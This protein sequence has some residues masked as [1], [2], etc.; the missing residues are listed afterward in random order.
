[1]AKQPR[2]VEPDYLPWS[3]YKDRAWHL[4]VGDSKNIPQAPSIDDF[5]ELISYFAPLLEILIFGMQK[6]P[7]EAIEELIIEYKSGTINNWQVKWWG[8]A[9]V[10][11]HAW[12]VRE[13]D[14]LKAVYEIHSDYKPKLTIG[15]GMYAE[16]FTGQDRDIFHL[17]DH[18]L[19]RSQL[20]LDKKTVKK[21]KQKNAKSKEVDADVVLTK[22]LKSNF[23]KPL[24]TLKDDEIVNLILKF[25]IWMSIDS[26]KKSPWIARYAI[27]TLRP[28]IDNRILGEKRDL[29]GMPSVEGYFTDDNSLI[30]GIY[31]KMRVIGKHNPYGE[32]IINSGLVCCHVWPGTTKDPQLFSFIPNLIWVPKSLSRYTDVLGNKPIHKIHYILQNCSISRFK[33]SQVR[34][35][36]DDASR[37]WGKLIQNNKTMPSEISFTEFVS[38]PKLSTLVHARHNRLIDFLKASLTKPPYKQVRFS[39]RYHLGFG[40]GI[41]KSVPKIVDL[42]DSQKIIELLEVIQKTTPNIEPEV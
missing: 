38:E 28:R 35:G 5:N 8:P 36:K 21:T 12:L 13:N 29:W 2:G 32:S 3:K 40:P 41:D 14:Y 16:V 10:D 42:V 6:D 26:Y 37:A 24:E 18:T 4:L 11:I 25:G 9:L 1:L 23:D 30:K 7:L 15:R 17:V 22:Y 20:Y 39:A 34:T 27:R 33:S 31:K 19:D